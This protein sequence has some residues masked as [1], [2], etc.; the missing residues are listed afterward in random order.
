MRL[1]VFGADGPDAAE[2]RSRVA[3]V[4]V[5]SYANSTL[6]LPRLIAG[7][8]GTRG[9]RLHDKFPI[10]VESFGARQPVGRKP[11]DPGVFVRC[12]VYRF[13][14]P[15]CH[16][17]DHDLSRFNRVV[18]R[19]QHMERLK[20]YP[21]SSSIASRRNAS[22]ADSSPSICPPNRSHTSG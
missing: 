16:G 10:S 20:L 19:A 5:G 3:E 15:C 11:A 7:T 4:G 8:A 13:A 6:P 21:W 17:E 2:Q 18:D 14:F 9:Y 22:S 1:E 12:G